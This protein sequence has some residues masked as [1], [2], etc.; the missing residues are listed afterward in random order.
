M[1]KVSEVQA[2]VIAIPLAFIGL[3]LTAPATA[4]AAISAGQSF[5]LVGEVPVICRAT[6]QPGAMPSAGSKI[7]SGVLH[8]FCNAPGGY[9]VHARLGGAFDQAT[10]LVDGQAIAPGVGGEFVV[11][12]SS[13]ANVAA[14]TVQLSG[15]T[16][17]TTITFEIFP[18]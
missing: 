6:V 15:V 7:F 12:R 5:S 1:L 3:A 14:R 4:S 13:Y 9:A 8:E 18:L 17:K 11:S 10:L 16:S 2:K